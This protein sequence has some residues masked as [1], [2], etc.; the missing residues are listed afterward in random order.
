[1]NSNLTGLSRKTGI[2][3]LDIDSITQTGADGKKLPGDRG[4]QANAKRRQEKANMAAIEANLRRLQ[5]SNDLSYSGLA[6]G[7]SSTDPKKLDSITLARLIDECR[8]E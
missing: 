1:M 4:L 6:E 2:S 8:E 7:V 3:L 5:S